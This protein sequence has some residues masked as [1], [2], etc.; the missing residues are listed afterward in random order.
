MSD[1]FWRDLLHDWAVV[2]IHDG[3]YALVRCR[4]CGEEGL[5]HDAPVERAA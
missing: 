2:A 3:D 4:I 1:V 5:L